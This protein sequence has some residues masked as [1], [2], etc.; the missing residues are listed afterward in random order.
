MTAEILAAA[1]AATARH[2]HIEAMRRELEVVNGI[3]SQLRCEAS[4]RAC[5]LEASTG[6]TLFDARADTEQ[7][8][9]TR[10]RWERIMLT[11]ADSLAVQLISAMGV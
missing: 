11:V 7:G 8:A 9:A 5:L 1:A 6:T 10:L 3:L 2:E 4:T